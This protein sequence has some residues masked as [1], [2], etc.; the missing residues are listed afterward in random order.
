MA[1]QRLRN[2]TIVITGA[3]GGLGEQIAFSS[4]K[5]GANVILL[6]RN[7]KRLEGIKP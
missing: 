1:N 2:K 4:A 5:N 3:S 7:I 6:A